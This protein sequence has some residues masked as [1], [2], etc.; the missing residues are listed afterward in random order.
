MSGHAAN[1]SAPDTCSDVSGALC[2]WSRVYD[3][4][5]NEGTR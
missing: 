2:V 4:R 3:D 5:R 1:S